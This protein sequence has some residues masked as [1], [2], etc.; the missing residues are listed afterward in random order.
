M[1]SRIVPAPGD[2]PHAQATDQPAQYHA[3]RKAAQCDQHEAEAGVSQRKHP[4]DRRRQGE[5]EGYQARRVVHQR[6]ALQHVHQ[7]SG[8]AVLGNGRNGHGVG[9]RK[10]CGQGEGHRQRDARQQPVDE[11]TGP[12]HGEQHQPHGQRHYRATNAP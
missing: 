4:G 9:R 10:H 1:G 5:L 6:L 11:V 2:H 8:Q 12:D 3:H 7:G